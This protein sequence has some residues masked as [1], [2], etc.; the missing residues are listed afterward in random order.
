M[1][2]ILAFFTALFTLQ[3]AMAAKYACTIQPLELCTAGIHGAS[4]YVEHNEEN[5]SYTFRTPG[6]SGRQDDENSLEFASTYENIGFHYI[7]QH[8]LPGVVEDEYAIFTKFA[9]LITEN[10]IPRGVFY[11]INKEMLIN[12]E[13]L[14]MAYQALEQNEELDRRNETLEIPDESGIPIYYSP[15]YTPGLLGA[16]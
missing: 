8:K 2:K 12:G 5:N 14:E 9:V 10:N 4:I 3:P 16:P 7:E 6:I 1:K 13:L 11:H 15:V